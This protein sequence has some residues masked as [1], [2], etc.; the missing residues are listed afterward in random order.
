MQRHVNITTAMQQGST[1]HLELYVCSLCSSQSRIL[2][3][4]PLCSKDS[5][6]QKS[7]ALARTQPTYYV[8]CH[9]LFAR[10]YFQSF[11]R[12]ERNGTCHNSHG[13]IWNL[14]QHFLGI[15]I[16]EHHPL[17]NI[18]RSCPLRL[19]KSTTQTV[20]T[21]SSKRRQRFLLRNYAMS[22]QACPTVGSLRFG[23]PDPTKVTLQETDTYPTLGKG[24]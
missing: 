21:S 23:D 16:F 17:S 7:Q 2:V 19:V 18:N 13:W 5:C 24:K 20:S 12:Q 9:R 4:A 15:Y 1:S 14:H 10:F 6:H 22:G 11:R 8:S 3:G